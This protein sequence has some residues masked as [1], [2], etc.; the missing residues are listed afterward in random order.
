M[1]S[2]TLNAS[3]VNQTSPFPSGRERDN[4]RIRNRRIRVDT[5]NIGVYRNSDTHTQTRYKSSPFLNM[6][7]VW[8]FVSLLIQQH[9]AARTPRI[10][11]SYFTED[12][13]TFHN[14]HRLC[15]VSLAFPSA[16][17]YKLLTKKYML[18]A[19]C[20]CK[21]LKSITFVPSD[22]SDWIL[23][24]FDQ[25]ARVSRIFTSVIATRDLQEGYSRSNKTNSL[26]LQLSACLGLRVMHLSTHDDRFLFQELFKG[27]QTRTSWLLISDDGF[28]GLLTSVYFPLNNQVRI[29][30]L[31]HDGR[32]ATIWETYQVSHRNKPR[33]V[34]YG[35]W[36]SNTKTRAPDTQ[37]ETK[38][39]DT[40]TTSGA[41]ATNSPPQPFAMAGLSSDSEVKTKT[42]EYGVLEALEGDPLL[43]RT[44]LTGLDLKCTTL[45]YE[46]FTI[47][48][49]QSNESV[50]L[51][52]LFGN[53]FNGIR[54]ITN[55]T[56][57]CHR[58]RDGQW[59]SV[60]GGEWTG[61]VKELSDGTA[62][63]AVAPLSISQVRSTKA[64]FLI[65]LMESG[66]N[67]VLKR[68]S[69]EDYMWS[70]Y[71]KQ[72]EAS[73]WAVLAVLTGFLFFC[74]YFA[75]Q[76]SSCEQKL[77]PSDTFI[78]GAGMIF[79]QGSTLKFETTS[80]R[81][82][83][84]M[85]LLLQVLVLAFYTS[86]LVSA[87]T[88]GPPLPPMED[89]KDVFEDS[90]LTI[91]FTRGSTIANEFNTDNPLYQAILKRMK[92]EDF[93]M[94]PEEGVERVLKGGYAYMAWEYFY[95]M[96]FGSEC[97]AFLLP[98]SYFRQQASI[99]LSKDS[100]LAPV[101][102]KVLLDIQSLG[103][104]QKWW[105]DLDVDRADCNALVTAPI[106]LKTV[107][108]PF[109]LLGCSVLASVGVLAVEVVVYMTRRPSAFCN[110]GT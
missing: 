31:S 77:S 38:E 60:V 13:L 108:T 11:E 96:N 103:L 92:D 8:I 53:L 95:R 28:P 29:A 32:M 80:K 110:E 16:S 1:K 4:N 73:I 5:C 24:T 71:T 61:M 50:V 85:L 40:R 43:R 89:L 39:P 21:Q 58:V 51:E 49:R 72:F 106:E 79:G 59:G 70:V 98:P 7:L 6:K 62:D 84:L 23:Q 87:L 45:E 107:L 63:I 54:E 102:N 35:R 12:Y 17:S 20:A 82:V 109:L 94:S 68:P 2:R 33:I 55:F 22:W 27:P 86:N 42:M 74:L 93:V 52:G 101:L 19:H 10:M 90:S 15:I 66:F 83:V 46:P 44:D 76:R 69:N 26:S 41:K 104:L 88:V 67:V 37:T 18:V 56:S 91:G 34:P 25:S 78:A 97:G 64:D 57:T 99:A 36:V 9:L 47:L 100:P 105:L 48:K 14:I 75:S 81:G 3:N 30:N 65:G